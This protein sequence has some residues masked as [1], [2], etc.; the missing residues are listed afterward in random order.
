MGDFI[1]LK[2]EVCKLDINKMVNFLSS[3]NNLKTKVNYLD[4]GRKLEALPDYF[5]NLSC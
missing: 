5:K 4:F 1:A 2:A 3:L